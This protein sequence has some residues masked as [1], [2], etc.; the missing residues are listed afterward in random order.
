MEKTTI[1]LPDDLK[2]AVKRVARE[3]GVSEAEVIRESIR[4]G[5]SINK[6]RPRGGLFAG[7]EPAARRVDE[8]LKGFGER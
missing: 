2:A 8:L 6:P 7:P 1:Y 5:V 4:A 3:R